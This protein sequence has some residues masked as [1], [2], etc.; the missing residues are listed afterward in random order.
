MDKKVLVGVAVLVVALAAG[1]YLKKSYKT[2]APPADV[3]VMQEQMEE[4]MGDQMQEEM[5]DEKEMM[6]EGEMKDDMAE[7]MA[8]AEVGLE[9][10]SSQES[11]KMI[12]VDKAMIPAGYVVVHAEKDGKPG[13]VIGRSELIQG[14]VENLSVDLDSA[15]EAGDT[16][17]VMLHV[18]D[19]DGEY[20]FPGDDTPARDANGDVVVKKVMIE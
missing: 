6:D 5:M 3:K 1:F 2:S 16:V 14:S 4:E 20:E 11:G 9:V 19:G 12:M 17:F 18:D 15:V 7:E 8:E 13:P 10:A